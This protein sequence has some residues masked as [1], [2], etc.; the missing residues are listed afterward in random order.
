MKL[1]WTL[2]IVAGIFLA[3]FTLYPQFKMWHL[4]GDDW[5]GHYA[6]NDIDEVAYASYLRALIDG[7]PRRNDPYTGRDDTPQNPQPES[8]F[9]IQFAA[10]Y[11]A[12]I[13]ARILGIGT[14][15][16]MTLSGALA[17]FFAALAVFWLIRK[18]TEDALI[19]FAGTLVVLAGGALAAGEGAIGEILGT[20]F[21]YPYYPAFRRYI[22]AIAVPAFFAMCLCVWQML[23]SKD[24]RKRVIYC[25]LASLCFSFTVFSYFYIWTTAA[26]WMACIA[27]LWLIARPENF[28]RDF[29]AIVALGAACVLPLAPYALMLS[30][31]SETMD[32]VQLLVYTHL[33]DLLRVPEFIGFAVLVL[34]AVG[35]KRG[36]FSLKEHSVIFTVSFALVPI[37]VFNQQVLTGRS[38][39]PIHYQVFIGNY[40]AAL[41]LVTAV[42]LYLRKTVFGKTTVSKFLITAVALLAIVWGFVECHYTVEVLDEANILRDQA[43]PVGKRLEELAKEEEKPHQST[44]LYFGIV[45][46]DD[47][48]TIA[49]QN[50]LWARHQHV[51]PGLTWQE[52]KERYYQYLYYM[53]MDEVTL[54]KRLRGGDFVSIISLFGWGRHSDRLSADWKPLTYAEIAA[55]AR[56]YGAY[57]EN[58]SSTE[59]ANPLLSSVIVPNSWDIDLG[60]LDRWYERD[61]GEIIGD[62]ILYRVKLRETK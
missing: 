27:V 6:Y 28:R 56:N 41:A 5:Q 14:P 55:E 17:G 62:Y 22:P 38:L 36:V 7:R 34:I 59:A 3:I 30:N 49:P 23:A 53:N 52:S 37:I 13:P 21:A 50:V 32:N 43:Y 9:S 58:F 40:V 16:A 29:Q 51:F 19:S 42:G 4:R 2:A 26:A 31:R 60:N 1:N 46:S 39:Q 61:A 33:P 25:V 57:R 54:E 24:L 18:I 48:P 12:A 35:I 15:W 10:P 47:F 20:G 11:T 8:L 45:E 44:V